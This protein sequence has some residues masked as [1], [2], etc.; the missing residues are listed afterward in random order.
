MPD[1][2][3]KISEKTWELLRYISYKTRKP[4][5]R[6][7]DEIIEGKIDPSQYNINI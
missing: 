1:H 6:I 3:L 5:K 7:I 2:P 4:M